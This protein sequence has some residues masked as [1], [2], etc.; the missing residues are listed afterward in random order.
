MKLTKPLSLTLIVVC[1]LCV[2]SPSQAET[3]DFND[4]SQQSNNDRLETLL[5]ERKTLWTGRTGFLN[6]EAGVLDDELLLVSATSNRLIVN[7]GQSLDLLNGDLQESLPGRVLYLDLHSVPR[8]PRIALVTV[9]ILAQNTLK[10]TVYSLKTTPDEGLK[11]NAFYESNWSLIRPLED[12]LY[13]QQYDPQS[14][15]I[16]NIEYLQTTRSG[17]K[18]AG[19]LG[20]PSGARLSS[21]TRLGDTEWAI[22]NNDGNLLHIVDGRVTTRIRGNFG[23]TSHMLQPRQTKWSEGELGEAIRLPPVQMK[24]QNILAVMYN[25]RSSGGVLSW[26]F[27]G[28]SPSSIEL[29]NLGGKRLQFQGSIGPLQGRVLDVEAPASSSN[30]L[31]WL[32]R[33]GRKEVSLEMIDFSKLDQK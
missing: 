6:F 9:T 24:N 15:W 18:P 23:G 17:Y 19:S 13:R 32:R 22:I 31:L 1:I 26:I 10:S 29:F 30:Q 25:P 2:T 16:E 4:L 8:H 7:T 12:Q 33:S 27:G 20:A 28:S 3:I 11:L 21:M 14:L 5:N